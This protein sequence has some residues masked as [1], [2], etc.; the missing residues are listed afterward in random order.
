MLVARGRHLLAPTAI[1]F[2]PRGGDLIHC[3]RVRARRKFSF[4]FARFWCSVRVF[5]ALFRFG[6]APFFA[7]SR[8][9]PGFCIVL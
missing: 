1:Q 3:R 4:S 8:L 2:A 6:A 5:K 7:A 9:S